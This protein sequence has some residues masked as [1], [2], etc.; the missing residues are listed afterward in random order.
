MI[1]Q[2]LTAYYEAM[3]KQGEISRRGWCAA[4]VSYA[5]VLSE[6]GE[7][8]DV[9]PL[10]E[11]RAQG[12]KTILVPRTMQVPKQVG[13]TSGVKAN[14]LCD[15]AGYLLGFSEGEKAIRTRDCFEDS[16]RRH[17]LLLQ[18]VNSP[19]A[20]AVCAFFERWNPEA[21]PEHPVVQAH[22]EELLEGGNLVFRFQGAF[23]HKDAAIVEAWRAG[24][25]DKDEKEVLG[26]CLVT[27]K[28]EPI[29]ELHSGI[30]GVKDSHSKGAPLVS[31][32]AKALDSYG[33]SN[34]YNAP[35]GKTAEFAYTTALNYLLADREHVKHMGDATVVYWAENAQPQYADFFT[36]ALDGGGTFDEND[37]KSAMSALTKGKPYDLSDLT[38]RPETRF[39][40]LGLSPN[41]A[42]L[43]VRFFYQNSFGAFME[44]IEAH[45]KRLEI[46][47]PSF[48]ERVRL[49]VSDLLYE[50]INKNAKDKAASPLLAGAMLRAVLNNTDYPAAL[51]SGVLLRVRAEGN[52]TRGRAAILKAVLSKKNKIEEGSFVKLNENTTYQPYVLGRLF[53]VLESLQQAAN[54]G[55]NSTI[56]D[57]YFV[58]AAATPAGIFPLLMRLSSAH[59]RK[60]DVQRR[61]YYNKQ[62][63]A[64]LEKVGESVPT[65][66]TLSDQEHFFLGYYHETQNRFA[67]K[68]KEEDKDNG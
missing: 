35:V 24:Q 58:S 12:K 63:G 17:L 51:E 49:T 48:D 61:V 39:Y 8:Q 50:T 26:R 40:V 11:E 29:A 47:K 10:K 27:G 20:R 38:L 66:Y 32:N 4:K 21:A 36:E 45:Y 31:F 3:A 43:S 22:R 64:L 14:F 46:I 59:L 55:I 67:G 1:L 37:L 9:M 7:L 62:I 30:K 2:A 5:L 68:K 56:K 19:A 44:N 34:G 42:R 28:K 41:I 18:P 16:K 53:A 65:R 25:E 23:V 15:G 6:R 60:L 52:V 13:R 54:K 57:K 33:K